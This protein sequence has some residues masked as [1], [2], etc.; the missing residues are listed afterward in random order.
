MRLL[1]G[2]FIADPVVVLATILFG[3]ASLV[4]S[5]FDR[6]GAIQIKIARA[7]AKTL[8]GASGIRVET[9]GLDQISATGSYVFIA[10]HVSYM[11]T[12]VMLANIP[13]Q[14]RFLAKRG[15]F[16]IPFLGQH[17]SRAGHIPVPREDARAAV[18]TM[19]RA[20]ETI[21]RKKISLLIFPEGGRSHDGALQPFKEG[22]A[23]IAIR[24]GV[25][26]VP[27]AIIGTGELLPWGSGIVRSGRV[28]L[29]I[30]KPIET[31]GLTLKDRARLTEEARN[32]ILNELEFSSS[33]FSQAQS[34]RFA[35]E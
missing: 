16:Q 12:P 23:Y 26:L 21:Q 18:K 13:V 17:L 33:P 1:R 19:Q 20:A 9:H 7:W 2:L 8:L 22:G 32:S 11:D 3:T 27:V 4:V 28:S 25:P 6:T 30:L 10:N 29:R 14:F 24:A 34:P 5:F 31:T 35:R 15:L